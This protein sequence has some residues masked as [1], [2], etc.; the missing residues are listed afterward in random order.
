MEIDKKFEKFK[1]KPGWQREIKIKTFG[2]IDIITGLLCKNVMTGF[3]ILFSNPAFF[4]QIR[5]LN[6][7][8]QAYF[9]VRQPRNFLRISGR[10]KQVVPLVY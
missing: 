7:V 8:G 3:Y 4:E 5:R 1:K 9:E 2:A 10:L 6:R